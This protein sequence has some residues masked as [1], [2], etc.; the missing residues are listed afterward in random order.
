MD[1]CTCCNYYS[2]NSLVSSNMSTLTDRRISPDVK[3]FDGIPA[4]IKT[5]KKEDSENLGQDFYCC[6]YDQDNQ[7]K[8]FQWVDPKKNKFKS[9]APK[10]FK[11][12]TD[13][14]FITPGK[15]IPHDETPILQPPK[16]RKL[17]ETTAGE[18]TE[19]LASG[20][21]SPTAQRTDLL[22]LFNQAKE[23]QELLIKSLNQFTTEFNVISEKLAAIDN[24][25]A[26]LEVNYCK[27]N[28]VV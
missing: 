21:V 7:C 2:Y 28:P 4:E 3:C 17:E 19:V 20:I 16:K 15:A 11:P 25:L 5:V 18:E 23:T 10:G 1:I 9:K 26:F 27:V 6:Q 14:P 12:R 24:R 13:L 22:T 8:F